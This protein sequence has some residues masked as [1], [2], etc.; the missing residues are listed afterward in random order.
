MFGYYIKEVSRPDGRKIWRVM[1]TYKHLT[2]EISEEEYAEFESEADAKNFLAEQKRHTAEFN[3]L[4]RKV[5]AMSRSKR[6]K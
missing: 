6:K 5:S 1:Q 2:G 4:S 3:K